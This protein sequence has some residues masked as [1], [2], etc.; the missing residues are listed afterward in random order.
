MKLSKV[1]TELMDLHGLTIERLSK[2]TGVSATNIIRMK[3]DV[4]SNP[5]INTL[6]PIASYFNLSIEQL[7]GIEKISNKNIYK[8][9]KLKIDKIPVISHQ[10]IKDLVGNNAIKPI[11]YTY[12][13][14]LISNTSFA[15]V[16]DNNI[17]APIFPNGIVVIFD[18]EQEI[19]DKDFV[20]AYESNTEST[21]F[22]QYLK[23]DKQSLLIAKNR[24]I[25]PINITNN[26]RLVAKAVEC[27]LNIQSISS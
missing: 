27:H 24:N 25:K 15:L 6:L 20:V 7:L 18:P 2:L 22:R 26:I 14:N 19:E 5:T 21:F 1:L 17:M 8:I 3:N 11:S 4:E 9:N 10:K 12:A 23:G 13:E 16:I